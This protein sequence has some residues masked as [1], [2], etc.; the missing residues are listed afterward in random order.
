[1]KMGWERLKISVQVTWM[2]W[3]LSNDGGDDDGELWVRCE[4]K[5]TH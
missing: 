5:S 2:I 4:G 1:M 3:D